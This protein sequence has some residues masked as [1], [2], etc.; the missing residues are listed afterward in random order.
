MST[1]FL[2]ALSLLLNKPAEHRPLC[3]RRFLI[4]KDSGDDGSIVLYRSMAGKVQYLWPL[5]T[6]VSDFGAQ[7]KRM[8]AIRQRLGWRLMGC[9]LLECYED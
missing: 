6:P 7:R 4:R 9:E 2:Q 8:S 3:M 1:N 5:Q